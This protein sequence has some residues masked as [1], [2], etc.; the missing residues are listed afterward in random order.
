MEVKV[1]IRE[2]LSRL[3]RRPT[4]LGS[5]KM[6]ISWLGSRWAGGVTGGTR[7]WRMGAM[8]MGTPTSLPRDR[9]G[10]AGYEASDG[11]RC[12]VLPPKRESRVGARELSGDDMGDLRMKS[13]RKAAA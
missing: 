12:R 7:M 13:V 11:V 6:L 4:V 9:G 8:R 2:S 1:V 10:V 3:L 5:A